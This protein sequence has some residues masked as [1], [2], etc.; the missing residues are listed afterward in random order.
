VKKLDRFILGKF[1]TTFVFSIIIFNVIA[2]V[3]DVVEHIDNFLETK[4][5]TRDI[6]VFYL[7]FVPWISAIL[8]PFFVF[9]AVIFFTSK[10]A[11]KSEVIA[12]LASGV[13]F[14]RYLRAYW[15]G[16]AL[17]AFLLLVGNHFIVPIANKHKLAIEL[18]YIAPP[19]KSSQ[20]NRHVR[21]SQ[22]QYAY[23]ESYNFEENIGYRFSLE[24]INGQNL[25]EKW[26][27]DRVSYD[28]AKKEWI[29]SSGFIRTN[30]GLKEKVEN[31]SEKRIKLPLTPADF[32]MMERPKEELTTNELRQAI[33]SE[34]IKG[35]GN[36]NFLYVER[37]RRTAAAFS[38]F[39]LTIIGACLG[40]RKVRGGSGLHLA[41][42]IIISASYVL[43]MQFS[44][45]FATK[46]NLHP[47]IA[48][49]IP[50][51]LFAGIAWYLLRRQT[52]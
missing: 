16:A 44:T 48:V 42:G 30:D 49:W 25:T 5:P 9:I 38:V 47:L 34:R 45:T 10:M 27:A 40:S 46:G 35:S 32:E 20:A 43:F 31:F 51:L 13:S 2:I 7:S 12:I 14:K 50:N 15:V 39:I 17:I 11:Y 1:L 3:I 19:P 29:V 41:L 21:L 37:Y 23:V 24:R 52:R 4:T 6:L 18:K 28:S 33:N 26:R 22:D 36:L 8:C